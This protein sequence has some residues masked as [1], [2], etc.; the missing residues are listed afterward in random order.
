MAPA[1]RRAYGGS[2]HHRHQSAP[3]RIICGRLQL[4]FNPPLG[5]LGTVTR[6]RSHCVLGWYKKM[7]EPEVRPWVQLGN[8]ARVSS[9][10]ILGT[11]NQS[12]SLSPR[13]FPAPGFLPLHLDHGASGSLLSS[14]G[15]LEMFRE[16]LEGRGSCLSLSSQHSVRESEF[17]ATHPPKH[18][19]SE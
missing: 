4:R 3:T 2:S 16:L 5:I 11:Q 15:K 1:G 8:Y 9:C 12:Y 14:P 18:W 13:P 6:P 19:F 17:R 7:H 10:P